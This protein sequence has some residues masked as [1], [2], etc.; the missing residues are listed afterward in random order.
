MN[1]FPWRLLADMALHLSPEKIAC[2]LPSECEKY[3]GTKVGCTNIAYP[4]MVVELMP[5]GEIR[6]HWRGLSLGGWLG[7]GFPW[8]LWAFWARPFPCLEASRESL[9]PGV[10]SFW[11]GLTLCQGGIGLGWLSGL[12]LVCCQSGSERRWSENALGKNTAFPR[13]SGRSF[14]VLPQTLTWRLELNGLLP[15]ECVK[16]MERKARRG[17]SSRVR[18]FEAVDGW[19]TTSHYRECVLLEGWE[20]RVHFG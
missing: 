18:T 3:C 11:V 17:F 13:S 10:L 7:S 14:E 6:P 2:A 5:N 4:T 12:G 1:V 15:G 16:N 20:H 19:D 9:M 8:I